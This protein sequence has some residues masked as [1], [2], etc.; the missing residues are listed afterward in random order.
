MMGGGQVVDGGQ[1][2]GGGQ[3][4]DGGQMGSSVIDNS[5]AFNAGAYNGVVS[6]AACGGPAYSTPVVY[7]QPSY[8]APVYQ[9]GAALQAP[10]PNYVAGVYGLAFDRDYEDGRQVSQNPRGDRLFT[11][12]ADDSTFD[13]VGVDL[14]RRTANGR[15]AQFRYWSLN[16]GATTATLNG[17]RVYTTISG[18]AGLNHVP[19]GVNV[20]D[21]M[22]QATSQ[23]ITREAD[24]YNIELNLLQ[25]GGRYCTRGGRQGNFELLGGFRYFQF[26][27]SLTFTSN[28]NAAAFPDIPGSDFV[29]LGCREHVA[30]SADGNAKRSLLQRPDSSV[31][32]RQ[33]RYLQQ[34]CL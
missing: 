26:D 27:E 16:P 33:R 4:V 18:L 22:G 23:S 34:Q 25:N 14:A 10:K 9:P 5:A 32:W 3:V 7:S 31:H 28:N 12:D 17:D 6:G 21:V 19:A 29:L 1:M 15:G 20:F 11:D 13:G 2:M 8:T 30:R 24:I